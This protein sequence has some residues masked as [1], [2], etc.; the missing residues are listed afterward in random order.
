[1]VIGPPR[2]ELCRADGGAPVGHRDLPLY[3]VD[4]G[5]VLAMHVVTRCH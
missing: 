3:D 2:R 5:E 4:G 1:M